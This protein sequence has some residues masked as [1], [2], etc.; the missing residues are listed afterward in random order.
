M[1]N[2]ITNFSLTQALANIVIF[3][4]AEAAIDKVLKRPEREPKMEARLKKIG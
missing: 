4:A 3:F 2:N 1:R